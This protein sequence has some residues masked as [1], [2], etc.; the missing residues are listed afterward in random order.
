MFHP[1]TLLDLSFVPDGT[2]LFL[3]EPAN[4]KVK[5]KN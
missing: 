2:A 4:P 5:F 3:L 1:G